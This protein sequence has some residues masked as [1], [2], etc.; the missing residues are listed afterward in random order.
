MA[1]GFKTGGRGKGSLNKVTAELRS[2]VTKSGEAPLQYMLRVMHDESEPIARRDDM[3]K[4]AA[5]YIHPRLASKDLTI[6]QPLAGLSNDELAD[7]IERIRLGFGRTTAGEAGGNL[8]DL[9]ELRHLVSGTPGED[10]PVASDFLFKGKL[11][12]GK[13]A[14]G[15]AMIVSRSETACRRVGKAR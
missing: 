14:H 13:Q 12:A 9:L 7:L 1:R 15:H 8:V 10:H 5:P 4:A 2:A 11:R 6:Q 3:A